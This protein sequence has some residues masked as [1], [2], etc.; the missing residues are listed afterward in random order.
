[1]PAISPGELVRAAPAEQL[2]LPGVQPDP[3]VERLD[4]RLLAAPD[5]HPRPEGLAQGEGLRVVVPVGVGDEE[6]RD[7]V[8]PVAERG[9]GA[10]ERGARVGH[11]PARVHDDEALGV[12]DDVH[13]DGVQRRD[14]QLQGIRC[15]PGATW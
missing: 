9:E 2:D 5:P 13:V 1:M 3:P 14:R 7:V 11:G 8:Q 4:R 6:L 10:F 12:L 15:T